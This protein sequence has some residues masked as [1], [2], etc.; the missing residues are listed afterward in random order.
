[1]LATELRADTISGLVKDPSGSV[2]ASA[3]IEITGGNL[4]QPIELVTDESGKFAAPNLVSG[5]YAVRV[6]KEGFDEIVTAVDL[7]GTADLQLRLTIAAQQTSIK[8]TEKSMA[9]A[10]SDAVYRQLRDVGLG[11]SYRCEK[12][13]LNL[14]AGTFELKS[15]TIT[16]LAPINDFETGAIFV[17]QGHFTLK[18]VGRLDT[19]EMVR[20]S[21]HPTAEEDFTQAVFRF[22]DGMYAQFSKSMGAKTD[23]PPEAAA[24]FED[25]KNKV[26]HR[27]EVPEGFTQAVLEAE[28]IDNVDAD[29]LAAIYNPKHPATTSGCRRVSRIL[30]R[31]CFS[32]KRW[33]RSGRRI[34][35]I[36]GNASALASWTRITMAFR[37][38]TQVRCGSACG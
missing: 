9:F 5:T 29:V 3:R 6:F 18:P 11:D 25:W 30:R 24:A 22:T 37:R 35:E 27:H 36:T 26:R 19:Q 4:S 32:S 8:V 16:L 23:T 1:M 13:V 28:T 17:G 2:V 20:R 12:F 31:G 10:N 34:T 33:G 15:G 21:G 14:D 38:T 7:R